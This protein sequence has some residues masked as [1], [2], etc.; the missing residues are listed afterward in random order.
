MK[1][2]PTLYVIREMKIFKMSYYD[3]SIRMTK[4]QNTDASRYLLGCGATGTL[5]QYW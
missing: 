4:V 1:R 2:W 3:T 5:T